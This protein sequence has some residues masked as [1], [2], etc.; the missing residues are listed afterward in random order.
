MHEGHYLQDLSLE[1]LR[2]H[3]TIMRGG[4]PINFDGS[5]VSVPSREIQVTR[6]LLLGAVVQAAICGGRYRDGGIKSVMLDPHLQEFVVNS[7]SKDASCVERRVEP[8]YLNARWLS[9]HSYGEVLH[10]RNMEEMF[11]SLE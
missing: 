6:R 3:L 2:A 8:E 10:C 1:L 5:T 9:E 7:W 4:F 11:G